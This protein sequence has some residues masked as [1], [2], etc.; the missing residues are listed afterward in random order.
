MTR[1]AWCVAA[2]GAAFLLAVVMCCLTL[3]PE[4][5]YPPL[6][7]TDLG[8]IPGA[9]TRIQLQQAQDR[10]QN[11]ARSTLLQAVAGLLVIVGVF[12][13]WRQVQVNR[14]GQLTDR[15]TKAIDQLGGDKVEV[16]VGAIYT[17]ERL[18]KNSEQDR[19]PVAEI[20][21]AFVRSGAPWHAGDPNSLDAH[22]TPS[23]DETL[24]KLR[25][26]APT[27]SGQ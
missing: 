17:L 13:T 9:D 24:P 5:L 1:R 11:S 12:T 18:A 2:I 19:T 8:A 14:E 25:D 3:I 4:L 16:R 6:T 26:R 23:I 10:M 27:C 22:P 20:L 7:A 15:L 21:T